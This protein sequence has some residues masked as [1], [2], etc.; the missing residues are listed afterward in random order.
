MDRFHEHD[1][2]AVE[3]TGKNRTTVE[4]GNFHKDKDHK[5]GVRRCYIFQ[6]TGHY[7]AVCP[8]WNTT[9][10]SQHNSLEKINLNVLPSRRKELKL[11]EN[12]IQDNKVIMPGTVDGSSASRIYLDTGAL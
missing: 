3:K 12:Y 5:K 8:L 7:K 4:T 9:G 10:L 2:D 6:K 11:M 1:R